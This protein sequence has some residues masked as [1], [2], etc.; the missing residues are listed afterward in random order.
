MRNDGL[1]LVVDDEWWVSLFIRVG[2]EEAGF[3]AMEVP[4]A[5]AALAVMDITPVRVLVTDL[6]LGPGPDGLALAEAAQRRCPGLPTV[7]ASGD[8]YR[9]G[10]RG[11]AAW[12]RFVPKP[13]PLEALVRVV[14]EMAAGCHA[15]EGLW[16]ARKR[17]WFSP[18]DA[19]APMR[20]P[21]QGPP[22][23]PTVAA[24]PACS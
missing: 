16:T 14:S 4:D 11:L 13:F 22:P 3:A 23:W 17:N 20:C 19:A 9:F 1:I 18:S 5:E 8:P 6:D 10:L 12:E 21:A 15:G 7:Y 2:L 24:R